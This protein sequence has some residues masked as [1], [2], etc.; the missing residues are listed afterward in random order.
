VL[1]VLIGLEVLVTSFHERY[2]SAMLALVP[3]VLTARLVS[4][5]LPYILPRR[6]SGA[7]RVVDNVPLGPAAV[8]SLMSN[9]GYGVSRLFGQAFSTPRGDDRHRLR[10]SAADPDERPLTYLASPN[11]LF[12]HRY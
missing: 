8:G 7:V 12:N 2:L 3:V 1:F 9:V 4:V 6:R 11:G 5:G 10:R